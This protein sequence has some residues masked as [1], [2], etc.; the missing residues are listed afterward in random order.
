VGVQVPGDTP[1]V[2]WPFPPADVQA[3]LPRGLLVD[4]YVK[5]HR[6]ALP[7]PNDEIEEFRR[8]L[9]TTSPDDFDPG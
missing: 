4:E 1:D 2:H 8:F 5:Q 9:D 6:V 3:L 7:R